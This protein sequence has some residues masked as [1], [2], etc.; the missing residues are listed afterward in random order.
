M[1]HLLYASV[2]VF[3]LLGC[4]TAVQEDGRGEQVEYRTGTAD[5]NWTNNGERGNVNITEVNW[6]GSVRGT[7]ADRRYDPGDVFIELR[8]KHNKPINLTGWIVTIDQNAFAD[9][10]WWGQTS[11]LRN[12]QQFIIPPR[13]NRQPVEP[14][15]Y[16]TIAARESG[17]FGGI[18]CAD[19]P[20]DS[21]MT[22]DG[23]CFLSDYYIEGMVLPDGPF[24][25]TIRDLDER[26]I[27]G[28]G[29]DRKAPFSGG[30]DLVTARSME[31][32]ALIFNNRGNRDAAWHSY[33]L[34]DFD[35][36]DRA[37]LHMRLRQNVHPAY[38]AHTFATPGEPNTPDY[39]GFVSS[40][41]FQ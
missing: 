9:G 7:G 20:P 31:R 30:Y 3:A 21:P 33:S 38:Q 10:R 32:I 11:G 6:S 19:A 14:N 39:S 5:D 4:D 16:V 13:I 27:D 12:R 24:D 25:V 2:S 28:G 17:A 35:E 18:D 40:G 22:D 15:E 23:L 36:G 34:N 1:R 26:L 41:D 29:D 8:N 37:A